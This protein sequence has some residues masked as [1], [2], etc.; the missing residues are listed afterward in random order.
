MGLATGRKEPVPG[1]LG[2]GSAEPGDAMKESRG[3]QSVRICSPGAIDCC[4]G[5]PLTSP[6][7]PSESRDPLHQCPAAAPTF[8]SLSTRPRVF[9]ICH[10]FSSKFFIFSWCGVG[11]GWQL[12]AAFLV[13]RTWPCSK[14]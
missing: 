9:D 4:D 2:L 5:H 12:S 10:F 14:G 6:P 3:S 1:G 13:F 8:F 7:A 11:G